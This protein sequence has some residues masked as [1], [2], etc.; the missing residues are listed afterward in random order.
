MA[1]VDI[2]VDTTYWRI[3]TEGKTDRADTL[4]RPPSS[5]SNVVVSTTP[6]A[7]LYGST[8]KTTV[9]T[10][11]SEGTTSRYSPVNGASVPSTTLIHRHRPPGRTSICAT[12]VDDP[13]GPHHCGMCSASVIAVHTSSRGASKTRSTNSSAPSVAMVVVP[14]PSSCLI[15]GLLPSVR[16]AEP[17]EAVVALA[18]GLPVLPHPP[19]HLPHRLGP[20]PARAPLRLPALLDPPR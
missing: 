7:W 20:Q 6:G 17:V 13:C 19:R 9:R 5:S 15:T 3:S 14:S 10:I 11:R 1:P 16:S 4:V 8:S 2:P 18:E 12:V